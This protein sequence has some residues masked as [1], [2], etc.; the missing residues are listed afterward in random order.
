MVAC[1][2]VLCY[3]MISKMSYTLG[4]VSM[5]AEIDV[6]VQMGLYLR[7]HLGVQL[8]IILLAMNTYDIRVL[9]VSSF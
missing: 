9:S 4:S 2:F 6:T 5:S 8:D 3:Y 1:Q 7:G